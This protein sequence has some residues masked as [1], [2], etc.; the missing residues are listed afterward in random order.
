MI[1]LSKQAAIS[2]AR[3]VKLRTRLEESALNAQFDASRDT[4]PNS[5]AKPTHL[6]R[7]RSSRVMVFEATCPKS[8]LIETP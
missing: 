4:S 3:A 5:Q 8:P 7:W 2:E 1:E 6:S